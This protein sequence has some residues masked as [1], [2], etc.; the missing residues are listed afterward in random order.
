MFQRAEYR[1]QQGLFIA[2][3]PLIAANRGIEYCPALETQK[4]HDPAQGE[5]QAGLLTTRLWIGGLIGWCVRQD[6]GR[7]IDQ[8][9]R[10][11]PANAMAWEPAR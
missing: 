11:A 4:A 7:A 5:P 10:N 3:L 6:H 8:P 2:A 9:D 1:A